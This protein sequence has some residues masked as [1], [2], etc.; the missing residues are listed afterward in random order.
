ME[1]II[2][3]GKFEDLNDVLLLVKEL[4]IYE[5]A[6]GE[7]TASLEDYQNAYREGV[8]DILVADNGARIVGMALFYPTYSTWK[9]LK[10]YLEDFIVYEEFRGN[11]IGRK[12]FDA[13]IS[14]ARQKKA[15]LIKLQAL[16]WNEPALNFYRKYAIETDDEWI[17][18]RMY[19]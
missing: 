19:L 13:F 8:F 2:R 18:I 15:R 12:L 10:Y 5:K 6:Q 9:G 1:I 16:K 4:A 17:D 3:K 14:M 11:G 7:V